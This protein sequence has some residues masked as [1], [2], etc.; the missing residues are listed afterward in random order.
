MSGGFY[1]VEGTMERPMGSE[2]FAKCPHFVLTRP[3]F[4]F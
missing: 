2:F 1:F 3:R 4:M